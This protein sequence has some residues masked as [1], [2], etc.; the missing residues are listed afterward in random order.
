MANAASFVCIQPCVHDPAVLSV[1]QNIHSY[2]SLRGWDG[3]GF[4]EESHP[5]FTLSVCVCLGVP[6]D[7]LSMVLDML[8]Q[9]VGSPAA[10][11]ES[12]THWCGGQERGTCHM[13]WQSGV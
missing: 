4:V 11:G 13:V 8:Q 1:H 10:A 7:G 5:L 9:V 12:I 2:R 6:E 3:K